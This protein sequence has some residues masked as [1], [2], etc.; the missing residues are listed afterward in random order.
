[1][2]DGLEAGFVP[3]TAWDSEVILAQITLH[4]Q[5]LDRHEVYGNAYQAMH[6][7]LRNAYGGR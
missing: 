3:A 7:A 1:V 4:P 2:V 5:A 6:E